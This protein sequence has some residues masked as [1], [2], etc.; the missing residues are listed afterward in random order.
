MHQYLLN[1]KSEPSISQGFK[2]K[3][4]IEGAEVV[5]NAGNSTMSFQRSL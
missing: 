3:R 4:K 5:E 2:K 1:F